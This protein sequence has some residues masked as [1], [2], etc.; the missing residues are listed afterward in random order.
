MIS[1]R[2]LTHL[3]HVIQLHISWSARCKSVYISFSSRKKLDM[4][5]KQKKDLPTKQKN[6]LEPIMSD[7]H[8]LSQRQKQIDLGK[9]TLGYETYLKHVAR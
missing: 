5:K 1:G 6:P 9:N 7:P 2:A 3:Y 4:D 8:R